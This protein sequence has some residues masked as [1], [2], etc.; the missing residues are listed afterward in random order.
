MHAAAIAA[1]Q[2]ED[3]FFHGPCKD[4]Q[5]IL[6][7]KGSQRLYGKASNPKAAMTKRILETIVRKCVGSDLYRLTP[8]A[9]LNL[10]RECI[11]E[12]FAYLAMAR[13]SDLAR[14]E[15]SDIEVYED[16][17]ILHFSTRKNDQI[18]KGHSVILLA[19]YNDLCPV[20]LYNKY[21]DRLSIAR[22][23]RY[24][25]PLLPA[26]GKKSKVYFPVGT[27]AGYSTMREC[28]KKVLVSINLDPTKFGLHSG[29][30]GA[31]TDSAAA[32][33]DES[34][35]CE[36]GGW[37]KDSQMPAHYDDLRKMKAKLKVALTLRLKL[38]EKRVLRDGTRSRW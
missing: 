13:F 8:V 2:E 37:N 11:F 34:E 14:L 28:Q 9:P 25:G 3:G 36:F 20:F 12:T 22:G 7:M 23:K 17:L 29:R 33:N 38:N 35:T 16:K 6:F 24:E 30:R 10:W 4:R 27:V 32:G 15:T 21:V 18:H 5:I 19:T 1:F 31:A 26:F